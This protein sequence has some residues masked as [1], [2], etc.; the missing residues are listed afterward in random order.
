MNYAVLDRFPRLSV[1]H[2]IID[3][4]EHGSR[5]SGFLGNHLFTFVSKWD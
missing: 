5:I 2:E 3:R 4:A 1:E